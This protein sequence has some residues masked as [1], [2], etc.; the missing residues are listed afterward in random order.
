MADAAAAGTE[1]SPAPAP[2]PAEAPQVAPVE[3]IRHAEA[4]VAERVV[5]PLLP[6]P[7]SRATPATLEPIVLP[8]DLE[9][10]ET[11]PE[12]LNMAASKAEPPQPPRPPR[13]RPSLPPVSDEP[14]VQI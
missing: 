8:P 14:L 4:P 13:V 1:L 11:D 2:Y 6:S 7:A 12:K 3:E 10:I 9:L 5:E